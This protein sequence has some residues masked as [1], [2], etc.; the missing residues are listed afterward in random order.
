VAAAL[1]NRN[2]EFL[3][4]GDFWIRDQAAVVGQP[5]LHRHEYFQ[6]YVNF[7]GATEHVLGATTQRIHPGTLSFIM[8]LR[9]HRIRH[10]EPAEFFVINFKLGFLRPESRVDALELEDIALAGMP[11][12]APF[13]FQEHIE[14]RLAGAE[15]ESVRELCER[16]QAEHRQ[17]D[18]YAVEFIRADL[19]RLIGI[20]CRR[21]QH[22]LQALAQTNMLQGSRRASLA[23]VSRYMR[24][25][26]R[27]PITLTDAACAAFLSTSY[28]AHLLK[29]ETGRTFVEILTAQRIDLA[30]RMLVTSTRPIAE[31]AA[32][33][34]FAD[35]AY[36]SRRFRQLRGVSPSGYRSDKAGADEPG[37]SA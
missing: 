18:F 2:D 25:H 19:F 16:M 24:E 8:P 15:L 3:P 17:G 20:V 6:V 31:I 32:S 1:I 12:L 36:F 37:A 28:L 13:L 33:V 21:Y 27:E 30:C 22:E 23:R 5:P 10:V 34:G 4:S 29:K 14:F 9:V 11:E 26:L 35:E 7:R